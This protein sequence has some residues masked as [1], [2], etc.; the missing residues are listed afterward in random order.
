MIALKEQIS[1][2]IKESTIDLK[3]IEKSIGAYFWKN[4]FRKVEEV[5]YTVWRYYF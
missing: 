2:A 3:P 5:Y 4:I 1:F